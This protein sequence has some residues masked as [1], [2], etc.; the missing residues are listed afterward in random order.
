MSSGFKVLW[1][2]QLMMLLVADHVRADPAQST[3]PVIEVTS[4]GLVTLSANQQALRVAVVF[5]EQDDAIVPTL[6]RFIDAKGNVLKRHRGELSEGKPVIAEFEPSAGSR[7]NE[8]VRVEVW[9]KLP[10]VRARRY[11]ILV[12]TQSIDPPGVGGFVMD[13]NGGGCG[14]PGCGPPISPGQHV[15]CDPEQPSDL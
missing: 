4:S 3:Q 8:L 10:G 9:H 12:T 14:C 15:N 6:V 5:A 13:W 11:P 7:A 1:G 2:A